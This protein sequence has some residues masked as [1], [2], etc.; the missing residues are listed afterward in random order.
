MEISQ[1]LN[2]LAEIQD[3][4]S[5]TQ[6]YRGYRPVTVALTSVCALLAGWMCHYYPPS[7]VWP[8]IAVASI[9]LVGGEMAYDYWANFSH[10]QQRLAR[11][12][13]IQFLPGLALGGAW[14]A[15]W[16][17]SGNSTSMLPCLWAM[18]YAFCLLS[19]RPHLPAGVGYVAVFYG[20]CALALT[21]P[22]GASRFNL[23]MTLTFSLG[24]GLLALILHWNQP[25]KEAV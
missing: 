5:R 15:I 24:Q 13:L 4:L 23:G 11:K 22:M 7:A 12:V 10:H 17:H 16:V 18:S 6:V 19:S 9:A 1:A 25:R 2:Q 20:L 8:A 3:K 21:T 14:T